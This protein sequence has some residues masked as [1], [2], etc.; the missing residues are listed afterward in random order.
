[1]I[2]FTERERLLYVLRLLVLGRRSGVS[3]DLPVMG[4]PHP[5]GEALTPSFA[6]PAR[7]RPAL[8]PRGVWLVLLGPLGVGFKG[9]KWVNFARRR[10][11]HQECVLWGRGL[12]RERE[13]EVTWKPCFI[14]I[15]VYFL[16][17]RLHSR[18]MGVPGTGI[19]SKPQ[20]QQCRIL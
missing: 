14:Y 2:M 17:S 19:E 7:G 11:R 4:G 13:S 9:Q 20:L 12:E 15:C 3:G 6:E 10:K 1:M 16:F 18:R 5:E 8:R